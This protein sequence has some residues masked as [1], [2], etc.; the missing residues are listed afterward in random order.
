MQ[1]S[2]YDILANWL[3]N[4]MEEHQIANVSAKFDA[5]IINFYKRFLYDLLAH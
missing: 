2:F 4:Y 5:S 1:L 3:K